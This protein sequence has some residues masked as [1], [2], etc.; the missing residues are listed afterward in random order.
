MMDTATLSCSA[1]NYG[2]NESFLY[3]LWYFK[4][5]V[6]TDAQTWIEQVGWLTWTCQPRGWEVYV[7]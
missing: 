4:R 1:K 6:N 5:H 2:C 3:K 7:L